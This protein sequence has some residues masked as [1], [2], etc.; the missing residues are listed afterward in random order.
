MPVVSEK[1]LRLAVRN[2]ARYG[3]TDVFP[4]PLENHWFYDEE[5]TVVQLLTQI[6][7]G[8]DE[9]V[10]RYPVLF[11]KNLAGVG[12]V[13][14]RAATQI[15]PIWNAYLLGL[16]LQI[17]PD[18][19]KARLPTSRNTVFSYRFDVEHDKATIFARD[20]GWR[21]FQEASLAK[22]EAHSLV[23]ATDISDFYP[24]A[25]HHRI[26]NALRLA[27]SNQDAV[28]RITVMLF[29]LAEGTSYGLPVGGNA[30]RILAE[31]LLN[32][33]DRLLLAERIEFTRFVDD[34][35]I[36]ADT[37]EAAQRALVT[38]SDALL[39]NE[40]LTLS[41]NKTRIL[42]RAEFRR[43]SPVAELDEA[44]SQEESDTRKFLR[45]R[46]AYDPYSSTA[47]SDY[48]ELANELRKFDIL[49][50]LT[51]EFRKT[52]VDE[53]LVRRL[54]K[55]VKF[56]HPVVRDRAVESLLTNLSM[57]YPV[58]PTVA[59]LLRSVLNDIGEGVRAQL[60]ERVRAL[61]R[62]DSHITLVPANKVYALRLLAHDPSE[63]ADPLLVNIYSQSKSDMMIKRDVVLTMTKRRVAYWLSDL[64]KR[65]SVVT[66]W[67]KR[68]L[69][70]ATYCLA[71]EGKYW[72]DNNKGALSEVDQAFLRWIGSKH[73]GKMWEFPL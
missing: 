25:Y 65:Y 67:E 1:N 31:L 33:I 13:G 40:G 72:R 19:E 58:F 62:E 55:S 53:V 37:R 20:L 34:Y 47:D 28:N 66:P 16:V 29:K 36:F 68:A 45:I 10:R 44:E 15:D 35:Y 5:D 42:T 54:V 26:E 7:E 60:F 64:L 56:L 21:S 50:M 17:A 24:R 22:A 32:R 18:I 52:R 57:L 59:I 27:T 8:F 3:D 73:S 49:S 46:L 9:W 30:A 51:R 4:L 6:D 14:F 70:L 2:I 69:L 48:E 41:R 71:D 39:R 38:L 12:H 11:V 63:E 61:L 43:G 23:L